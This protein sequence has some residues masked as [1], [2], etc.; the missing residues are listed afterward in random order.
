[1]SIRLPPGSAILILTNPAA[2]IL[3]SLKNE[4]PKGV[5]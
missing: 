4:E 5:A 1:M 3:L 2:G